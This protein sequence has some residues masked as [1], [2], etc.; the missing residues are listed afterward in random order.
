[1]LLQTSEAQLEENRKALRAALDDAE[2]RVARGDMKATFPT[3]HVMCAGA[4]M[5]SRLEERH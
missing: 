5:P 1:M 2:Q 3:L 4:G